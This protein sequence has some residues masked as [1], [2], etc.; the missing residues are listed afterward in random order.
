MAFRSSYIFFLV[1]NQS[2]SSGSVALVKYS[3]FF[4][5]ARSS[6]VSQTY[7]TFSSYLKRGLENV[8]SVLVV[9]I[10]EEFA[11]HVSGVRHDSQDQAEEMTTS[12]S[13]A[14]IHS[15]SC[16]NSVIIN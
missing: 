15:P 14:V 7:F 1:E 8:E 5:K 2:V 10:S 16:L 12:H 11:A 6:N 3:V 9:S 13:I 4:L